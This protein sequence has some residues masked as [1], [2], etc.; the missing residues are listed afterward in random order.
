MTFDPIFF[1][2]AFGSSGHHKTHRGKHRY[3]AYH[4]DN[5]W[6]SHNRWGAWNNNRS[7]IDDVLERDMNPWQKYHH[8]NKILGWDAPFLSYNDRFDYHNDFLTDLRYNNSWSSS[9]FNWA[10][11]TA[12]DLVHEMAYSPYLMAPAWTRD[13]W[14]Y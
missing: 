7:I 11:K 5:N 8:R 6:D 2:L 3:Y 1:N 13:S 12:S 14:N 9:Q 4:N 10:P